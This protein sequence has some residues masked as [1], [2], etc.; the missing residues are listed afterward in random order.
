[1]TF[2]TEFELPQRNDDIKW[3]EDAP[4]LRRGVLSAPSGNSGCYAS[5]ACAVVLP[6]AISLEELRREQE[7][8]AECRAMHDDP[9]KNSVIDLNEDGVLIRKAPLDGAEQIIVPSSLRPRLLHLEHYPPVAGHP[10]VT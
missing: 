2:F 9:N 1:M 5:S 10:G 3:E 7:A 4:V 6:Q 8:D